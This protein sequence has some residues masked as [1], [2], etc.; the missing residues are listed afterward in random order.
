MRPGG[1]Q[2]RGRLEGRR[3]AAAQEEAQAG[4]EEEIAGTQH[5]AFLQRRGVAPWRPQKDDTLS[6]LSAAT[7]ISMSTLPPPTG[8]YRDPV[9]KNKNNR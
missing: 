1:R 7:L 5:L 3:E 8:F 6:S 2:R 9:R 4:A